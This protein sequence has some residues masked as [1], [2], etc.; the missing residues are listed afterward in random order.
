MADKRIK[1]IVIVG[2]G[3][4]GWMTAA[5]MS[6]VLGTARHSITLVESEM[7][8]TIGVGEA[9][10]PMIQLYNRVLGLDENE[11]VRET[12]ATFKLGIEFVDWK[13]IGDR[14]FHPFG[15]IGVDMDGIVFTRPGAIAKPHATVGASLYIGHQVGQAASFFTLVRMTAQPVAIATPAMYDRTPRVAGRCLHTEQI[16]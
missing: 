16:R 12:N 8:G 1:N 11:F 14:Y 2:G 7:I 9:T 13:K 10:I 3:T 6:K 4:A 15:H 5:A